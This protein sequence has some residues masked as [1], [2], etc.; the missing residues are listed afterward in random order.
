MM[1]AFIVSYPSLAAY[2]DAGQTHIDTDAAA[3]H[4]GIEKQTLYAWHS[5]ENGPILPV[6]RGRKLFWNVAD[7]ERL[8]FSGW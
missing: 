5:K 3:W 2:R 4:L 1:G 6:K 7:V 8:K